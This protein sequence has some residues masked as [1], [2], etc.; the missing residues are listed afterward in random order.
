[1]IT[2]LITSS[3]IGYQFLLLHSKMSTNTKKPNLLLNFST[4][5]LGGIMGWVVVHP[6]NTVATRMNLATQ[7]AS[8]NLSFRSY[9]V[10]MVNEQGVLSLYK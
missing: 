2:D 6:F 3:L 1:M 7:S 8:A 9:F 5:G 10:K 4:A